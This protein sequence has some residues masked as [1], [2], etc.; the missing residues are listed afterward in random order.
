MKILRK[1]TITILLI[2][3]VFSCSLIKTYTVKSKQL[4]SIIGKNLDME[5]DLGILNF[6]TQHKG[7]VIENG[8][9]YTTV[10]FSVSSFG[11]NIKG[12]MKIKYKLKYSNDKIYLVDMEVISMTDASGN[13]FPINL[14]AYKIPLNT[15]SKYIINQEI[16]DMKNINLPFNKVVNRIEMKDDMVIFHLDNKK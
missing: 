12:D 6:T 8:N 4:N 9:I 5:S 13:K 11:I 10:G 16:Y 7:S 14:P 15:I 3:S 1:I 2:L